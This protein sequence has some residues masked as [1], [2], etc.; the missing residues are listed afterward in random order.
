MNQFFDK[1]GVIRV[2]GRLVNLVSPPVDKHPILLTADSHVS[3]LI[4][5][6]SHF[7]VGHMSVQ[8]KVSYSKEKYWILSAN[9]VAHKVAYDCVYCRQIEAPTMEQQMAH[10]YPSRLST[11]QPCFTSTGCGYFSPFFCREWT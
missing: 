1:N 9:K 5:K 8:S 7:S 10:L 4:M 11:S 2:E 6:K 3:F